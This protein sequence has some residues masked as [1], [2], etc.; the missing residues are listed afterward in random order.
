MSTGFL[1]WL[2]SDGDRLC[3]FVSTTS[4]G[5]MGLKALAG[6]GPALPA[7]VLMGCMVAGVVAASAHQSFFPSAASLV[8]QERARF[9]S[10]PDRQP[11]ADK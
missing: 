11:T 6:I 5:L 10:Q 2:Q 3:N 8:A 1:A 7:P 4:L 9:F